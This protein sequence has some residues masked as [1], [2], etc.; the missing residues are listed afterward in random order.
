[1][2]ISP[3]AKTVN[4]QVAMTRAQL[5]QRRGSLCAQLADSDKQ[6]IGFG[7]IEAAHPFIQR[8]GLRGGE[9]AAW[10]CKQF[11]IGDGG[12]LARQRESFRLR[13]GGNQ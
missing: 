8:G 11:V 3:I 1:M 10:R 7:K 2:S 5:L 4:Q 6:A 9:Q 12:E 13:V